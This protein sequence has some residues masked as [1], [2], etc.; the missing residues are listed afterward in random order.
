MKKHI[1]LVSIID[2]I[3]AHMT[4]KKELTQELLF[5]FMKKF[6]ADNGSF[7]DAGKPE[8][9][10]A[11]RSRLNE[12]WQYREWEEMSSEQ[13]FLYG[14]LYGCV[15]L[16]EYREQIR[17]NTAWFNFLLSKYADSK[18]FYIIKKKPG[19]RHK[20][21]AEKIG[22]STGRLSQMMDEED[23]RELIASRVMGREKYYFLGAKGEELLQKLETQKRK[24]KKE[25]LRKA[26]TE[27]VNP[28]ENIF[29]E[30]AEKPDNVNMLSGIGVSKSKDLWEDYLQKAQTSYFEKI[31]KIEQFY[32]ERLINEEY[33]NFNDNLRTETIMEE[34]MEWPVEKNSYYVQSS[35][36]LRNGLMM[37][38]AK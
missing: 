9:Y 25:K 23:M 28:F 30:K 18:L 16:C 26:I 38:S 10:K 14:Q 13:A 6:I 22:L 8:S 29:V 24:A 35:N 3:S 2:D 20:D 34:E 31:R 11:M 17:Q 37:S 36:H 5:S 12:L 27:N 21:L 4:S 19:I 33:W 32:F 7:F 1:T 15:K